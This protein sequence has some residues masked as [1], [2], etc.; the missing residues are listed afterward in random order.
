MFYYR[1]FIYF[2]S[3]L[4]KFPIQLTN[5]FPDTCYAANSHITQKNCCG[6]FSRKGWA[7]TNFSTEFSLLQDRGLGQAHGQ[8]S[9]KSFT[10]ALKFSS[11]PLGRLWEEISGRYSLWY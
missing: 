3:T 9:P 11:G 5:C 8:L 6:I 1:I 2:K 4:F 7:G 10:L